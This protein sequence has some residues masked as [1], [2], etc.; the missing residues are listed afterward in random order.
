MKNWKIITAIALAVI[1]IVLTATV[2]FASAFNPYR[3]MTPNTSTGFNGGNDGHIHFS[4]IA[5]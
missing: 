5:N 2:A 4:S 1:A 3:A